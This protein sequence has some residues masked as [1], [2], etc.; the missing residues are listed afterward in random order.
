ML[1]P[2]KVKYRKQQRG[3]MRG[4]ANRGGTLAFGD[5]G[6]QSQTTLFVMASGFAAAG[7]LSVS[8]GAWPARKGD[9]VEA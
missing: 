2:S 8:S 7:R 1:M 5:M 3:R 6:L 4:K 9:V